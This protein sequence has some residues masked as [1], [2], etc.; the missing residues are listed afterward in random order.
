MKKLYIKISK[1]LSY[2]L[3]HHPEKFNLILDSEGYTELPL[4]LEILNK[5]FYYLKKEIIKRTIFDI[6]KTSDKKR[7]EIKENRIRA[8]YGHSITTRIKIAEAISLPPILYHGTT[9]K[10]YNKIKIEGLNKGKRQFV[11]LSEKIETAIQVG[12]RRS[13]SPIILEINAKTA[14]K[15]G[16]EF[17]KSGD[18]YLA[19]YI[20]PNYISYLN[21]KY[22]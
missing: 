21:E 4:V 19:E 5:K 8:Y 18:M 10:A 6:I 3:R 2:I 1:F 11:H 17:Y 9:V 20:P 12:K 14:Q 15:E 13:K 22:K 16:V 7:F